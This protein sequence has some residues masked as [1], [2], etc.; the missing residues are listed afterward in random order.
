MDKVLKRY[1]GTDLSYTMTIDPSISGFIV[2]NFDQ[3]N[4]FFITFEDISNLTIGPNQQYK[5][6]FTSEGSTLTI[7]NPN[8][9]SF[10]ITLTD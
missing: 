9:C 3:N 1:K 8:G 7:T 4:P 2:C 10:Y 5:E 6:R